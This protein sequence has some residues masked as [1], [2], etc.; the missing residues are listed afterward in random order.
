M[1]GRHERRA[2][3]RISPAGLPAL[4]PGRRTAPLCGDGRQSGP[5]R[6]RPLAAVRAPAPS[7]TARGPDPPACTGRHLAASRRRAVADGTA[8]SADQQRTTATAQPP[9]AGRSPAGCLRHAGPDAAHAD[10]A[11]AEHATQHP[12]R[13]RRG[14]IPSQPA[15]AGRTGLHRQPDPPAG[16]GRRAQCRHQQ[17]AVHRTVVA[18][19]D[20][21]S[22]RLTG[23]PEGPAPD[24]D[25]FR[26]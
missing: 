19:A 17:P 23:V 7:E 16:C 5:G 6:C 18:V 13:G 2:A 1:R 24:V 10:P 22:G 21:R 15:V 8:S 11:H 14:D 26:H 12:A 3:D 20:L 9:A 4:T 25:P